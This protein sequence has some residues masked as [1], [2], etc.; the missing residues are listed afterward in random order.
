MAEA[1]RIAL[2]NPPKIP[3]S[4]SWSWRASATAQSA[5]TSPKLAIAARI[6]YL[7][8]ARAAY[9]NLLPLFMPL[10]YYTAS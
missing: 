6:L 9:P 8:K 4:T 5:T 2:E 1:R 7:R 3:R 10:G